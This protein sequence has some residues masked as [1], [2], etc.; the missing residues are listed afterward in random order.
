M[1]DYVLLLA[2]GIDQLGQLMQAQ[3]FHNRAGPNMPC[4]PEQILESP[5]T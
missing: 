3:R 2:Q 4:D 5:M 1:L